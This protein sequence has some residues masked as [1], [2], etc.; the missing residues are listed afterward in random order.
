LGSAATPAVAVAAIEV[1][2]GLG[3]DAQRAEQAAEHLE[4][5]GYLI[6]LVH[7][8]GLTAPAGTPGRNPAS[9]RRLTLDVWSERWAWADPPSSLTLRPLF[10]D[11]WWAGQPAPE[12]SLQ[13]AQLDQPLVEALA[14]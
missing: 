11:L 9:G 7:L 6:R 1:R 3:S 10:N 4:R 14:G 12:V 5:L 13:S 2:D 8:A